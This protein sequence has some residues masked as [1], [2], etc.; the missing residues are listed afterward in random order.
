MAQG[1]VLPI[2]SQINNKRIFYGN[3]YKQGFDVVLGCNDVLDF[4]KTMPKDSVKLIVTSPPY[5]IGKSY[6]QK[7]EL[8][9]YLNWQEDVL[10]ECMRILRPD[11]SICWQV[12]N[13][14]ED[15]EVFPL[16][17]YF[18]EIFK[19]KLGLKLRN[20]IIWH[21]EHGLHASKR[22]SG[23]YETVIWFTKSNEYTFNLDPIRVPQKYPGKRSYKGDN[24]G[25]PSSNPLG[26]NPSDIW[27]I[28][29]QD[30]E[31]EIWTIPNVKSNHIEKTIHP[32]QFPIELVERLILAL[33]KENDMVFDPFSG[34]G[35]SMVASVIN[36]R[37]AIGV[38]KEKEYTDL[39]YK[40]IIEGINNNLKRRPLGKPVHTPTG[41]ESVSKIP[42][43]WTNRKL[44]ELIH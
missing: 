13:F 14:I 23:R 41:K 11:G 9:D 5:N 38:D 34:V 22:L 44:T 33:T 17:V 25:K 20:R 1:F 39:A 28:V 42:V 6:E 30:W 16:D 19:K 21:F 37:R 29:L 3:E 43:E 12:G 35:S 15:G 2:T 8:Q 18:Y 36:N 26:K 7:M 27:K 31:K 24:K 32:C 40:R 10:K 4:I